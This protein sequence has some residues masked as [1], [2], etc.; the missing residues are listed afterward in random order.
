MFRLNP[1]IALMRLNKPIGIFLLA[2]PT[3]W[4]L[5]LAAGGIPPISL[6]IIFILGIIVVRSAGCVINDLNDRKFDGCVARTRT[7]PL[8]TG[9]ITVKSAILLFIALGIIGLILLFLLN[10]QSIILGIIAAILTMLYP[11]LKRFTSFAQAGLGI[12]FNFGILMACTAIKG[13][14][15]L[16]G[17][18]LYVSA[19]IWTI[20][21]DTLYAMTDR[22]DDEKIG[23]KSTA[24]FFGKKDKLMIGLLQGIF[25]LL[26]I[27]IG[28]LTQLHWIYY[29]GVLIACGF[30][31]YQPY[32]IVHRNPARCFQA[33]L[34]NHWVGA[35]IFLGIF[36]N[37]L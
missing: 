3:L 1:Y 32:L 4:A 35:V 18:L 6:L 24:V 9:V 25:F 20:A 34:N 31:I 23:L 7:R 16:V 28:I 2:W 5:W 13:Y 27:V 29:L 12:T 17:Y 10:W 22:E 26:L 37:A 14:I 8:A 36:L 21:Y 11:L 30:A 19:I 15:P 33:F